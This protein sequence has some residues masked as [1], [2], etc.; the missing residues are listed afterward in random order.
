MSQASPFERTD[1][2]VAQSQEQIRKTLR[3]AGALGVLFE[4]TWGDQPQCIVRFV[5]PLQANG[6]RVE[7]AIRLEVSPLPPGRGQRGQITADQR[8]R[9]AWRGLAWYLDSPIKAAVFGLI[10]FEDIFLSFMELP[11]R[12]TLG[13]RVLGRI[14]ETGRL[15]LTAGT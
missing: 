5:W 10:R 15:E 12:S 14:A 7:Q 8:E 13:E 6:H 9:Q 2:A 1:I 11:D 4:S 3:N